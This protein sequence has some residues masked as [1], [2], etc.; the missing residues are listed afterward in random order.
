M[1]DLESYWRA[2]GD[3]GWPSM[4]LCLFTGDGLPDYCAAMPRDPLPATG[5]LLGEDFLQIYAQAITTNTA[6][7]DGA[8]MVGRRDESE[9]YRLEGWSYRLFPPDAVKTTEMNRGSA[10][11]SCLAM[12]KAA[13]VDA[14][15]LVSGGRLLR[16]ISGGVK[17]IEL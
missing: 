11:N 6:I 3:H 9:L 2:A 8:I 10:F 13:K 14:T 7:H 12:S 1:F 4:M 17:H 15:Y 5:F 16:F